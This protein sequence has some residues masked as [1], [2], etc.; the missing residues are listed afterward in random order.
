LAHSKLHHQLIN[1]FISYFSLFITSIIIFNYIYDVNLYHTF[2]FY[3][4]NE[5]NVL[6]YSLIGYLLIS[7]IIGSISWIIEPLLMF[8]SRQ[9]EYCADKYS[10]KYTKNKK[11]MISSLIKLSSDN[12]SDIFPNKYYE[13]FYYSHPSLINRIQK[14][15]KFKNNID[16]K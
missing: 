15:L 11:A 12:Y 7:M 9:C 10:I 4:I 16:K 6:N 3:W 8:I 5:E 1:R 2:G 14:I 13:M